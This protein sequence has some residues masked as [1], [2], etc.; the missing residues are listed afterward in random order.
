MSDQFNIGYCN[1]H[2]IENKGNMKDKIQKMQKYITNK[3]YNLDMFAITETWFVNGRDYCER[4]PEGY[5]L[6]HK[7]R[8]TRGGGVALIVKNGLKVEEA[9]EEYDA[10][11]AIGK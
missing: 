3:N 9:E 7:P 11:E 1:M 8:G 4:A 2:S 5:R 10:E 6:F